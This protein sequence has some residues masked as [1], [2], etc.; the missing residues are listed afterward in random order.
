V[1][2]LLEGISTCCRDMHIGNPQSALHTLYRRTIAA[3]RLPAFALQRAKQKRKPLSPALGDLSLLSAS[4]KAAA[5]EDDSRE[6]R[7]LRGLGVG[8]AK[9]RTRIA[10]A[11]IC[12]IHIQCV[13]LGVPQHA[14]S[15]E[16]HRD[17]CCD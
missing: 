2:M 11:F 4:L 9:Q 17:G 5:A 12:P 3:K 10:C 15:S 6:H 8:G 1:V 14:Q 13:A 16:R 7:Q